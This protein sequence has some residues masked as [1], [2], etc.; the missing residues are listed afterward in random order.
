M[1]GR[2]VCTPSPGW[3]RPSWSGQRTE[4]LPVAGRGPCAESLS[5]Q[6][7]GEASQALTPHLRPPSCFL[8]GKRACL[9]KSGVCF[10][11]PDPLGGGGSREPTSLLAHLGSRFDTEHAD[12]TSFPG[13]SRLEGPAVLAECKEVAHG[14]PRQWHGGSGWPLRLLH[15]LEAGPGGA[16]L[17]AG[18]RG[19]P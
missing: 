16:G 11:Q 9:V 6:Q 1:L 2:G 15:L 5:A 19:T 12:S 3:A 17:G 8:S 13:P 14:P 7:S 18:P 4:R 10:L